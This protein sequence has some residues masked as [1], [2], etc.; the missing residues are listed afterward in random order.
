[1]AVQAHRGE[2]EFFYT[3]SPKPVQTPQGKFWEYE[4]H[5]RIVTDDEEEVRRA[6][7]I[8]ARMEYERESKGG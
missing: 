2:G 3:R 5:L 4:P 1:M 6:M 8:L 7:M